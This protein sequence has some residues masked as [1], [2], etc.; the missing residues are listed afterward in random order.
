MQLT[1]VA[2]TSRV[3]FAEAFSCE[4]VGNKTA[5]VVSCNTRV[6]SGHTRNTQLHRTSN[7]SG[8][9]VTKARSTAQGRDVSRVVRHCRPKRRSYRLRIPLK[10][11]NLQIASHSSDE[12]SLLMCSEQDM[13][14]S[15]TE[16]QTRLAVLT[17]RVVL[18][19]TI[20]SSGSMATDV[21]RPYFISTGL[22]QI[23]GWKTTHMS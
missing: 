7:T 15:E 5:F 14:S 16:R 6:I 8:P 1:S 3:P 4:Q 23:K 18:S 9:H 12:I 13:T 20:L 22:L 2:N 21:I 10:G 11:V 17:D 19:I